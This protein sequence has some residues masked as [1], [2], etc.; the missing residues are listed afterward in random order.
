MNHPKPLKFKQGHDP[1]RIMADLKRLK[2]RNACLEDAMKCL[3]ECHGYHNKP[4]DDC[5]VLM[6][7]VLGKKQA[8]G[9]E[10]V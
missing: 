1:F 3:Y 8:I 2:D 5:L 9:K 10:G 6:R 7:M 4:C